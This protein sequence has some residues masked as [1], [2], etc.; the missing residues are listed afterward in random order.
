MK[1]GS[2]YLAAEAWTSGN[3]VMHFDNC[4]NEQLEN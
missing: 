1:I 4:S 2:M 3:I